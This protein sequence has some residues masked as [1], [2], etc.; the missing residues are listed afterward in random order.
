MSE[1]ARPRHRTVLRALAALDASFL[2]RTQCWFGG[3]TRIVLA[4]DEYRESADIDFLCSS[5]E[6]YRDLRSA[7]SGASLGGIAKGSLKL[8][9][10]VVADRYGIR[11]FLEVG[12]EKLKLEII[13]EGRIG[14]SG[15]YADG[16][17]VPALDKASCCAEKFLA[18]ADRWGD[19]SALGR[20]VIDLA[21]MASGWGREPLRAG[22]A[23]AMEA[24]GRAVTRDAKR[25]ATTMLE[26]A[27]WRKRC[28]AALSLS[29]T[30][31]L[32]S[33]LR[34]VAAGKW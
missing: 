23:I 21:F 5:R 2:E 14:L 27:D 17:P 11:T 25:A 1:P 8:A 24:Y 28:V 33:G 3:G 22:L 15:G 19:E 20:D 31:M 6:G 32:L 10:E 16:L 4:L 18:N 29:D 13:L 12:A 34:L 30:R 9:R 26:R 7:V